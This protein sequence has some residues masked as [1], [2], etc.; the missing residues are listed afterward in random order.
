MNYLSKRYDVLSNFYISI[1]IRTFNVSFSYKFLYLKGK[2]SL[3]DQGFC[4][5]FLTIGRLNQSIS[6]SNI[7]LHVCSVYAG[8]WI[9]FSPVQ[10]PMFG[11]CAIFYLVVERTLNLSLFHG[12]FTSVLAYSRFL[13]VGS[14]GGFFGNVLVQHFVRSL[15]QEKC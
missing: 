2:Y 11:S 7:C 8:K 4:M 15:D 10:Y 1:V 3:K 5:V 13:A 6:L 14:V 12:R 9:S